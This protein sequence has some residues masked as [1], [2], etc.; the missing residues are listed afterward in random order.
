MGSRGL[1]KTEGASSGGDRGGGGERGVGSRA[2]EKHE[3]ALS[4]LVRKTL[5]VLRRSAPAGRGRS[6][7]TSGGSVVRGGGGDSVGNQ[8]RSVSLGGRGGS[9]STI[10]VGGGAGSSSSNS[11]HHYHHHHHH[12]HHHHHHHHHR[13]TFA[14]PEP[15]A[16]PSHGYRAS[17]TT[18][19]EFP[20]A[21]QTTMTGKKSKQSR[22][23]GTRSQHTSDGDGFHT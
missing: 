17:S 21:P 3:S 7:S 19:D 22:T 16:G 20:R 8:S 23:G 1:R 13:E 10:G 2:Q 5:T 4:S 11:G 18:V 14:F 15:E 12:V 6:G 9:G